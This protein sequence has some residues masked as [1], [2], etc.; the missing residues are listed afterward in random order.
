MLIYFTKCADILYDEF[1]VRTSFSQFHWHWNMDSWAKW[2]VATPML[3][4]SQLKMYVLTDSPVVVGNINVIWKLH[5]NCEMYNTMSIFTTK[6]CG[7]ATVAEMVQSN[8]EKNERHSDS[9]YSIKLVCIFL[10]LIGFHWRLMSI[11]SQGPKL[12][13]Y[14]ALFAVT[15]RQIREFVFRFSLVGLLHEHYTLRY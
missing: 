15:L 14:T 5:S 6:L 12:N 4:N 8:E 9:A 10:V 3:I 2:N 7:T 13:K 11:L 1:Y